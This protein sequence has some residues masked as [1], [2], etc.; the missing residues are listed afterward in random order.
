[1]EIICLPTRSLAP[2]GAEWVNLAPSL[3]GGWVLE[4]SIPDQPGAVSKYGDYPH[5]K[6]AIDA[7]L[8]HAM[9]QKCQVLFVEIDARH[10]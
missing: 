3:G 7:A 4:G 8:E 5:L 1:M 6:S 9:Q 2:A 10:C